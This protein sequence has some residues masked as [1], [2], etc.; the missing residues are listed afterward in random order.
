MK[1]EDLK[2]KIA[3]K[4][5]NEFSNP[6]NQIKAEAN[7]LLEKERREV[8]NMIEKITNDIALMVADRNKGASDMVKYLTYQEEQSNKNTDR[9]S[10]ISLDISQGIQRLIGVEENKTDLSKNEIAKI[11]KNSLV[12][13]K[14]LF[15]DSQIPSSGRLDM[16]GNNRVRTVE[17]RFDGYSL[18]TTF[19]WK[20][21]GSFTWDVER[22]N[23]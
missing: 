18:I 17:E 16:D 14:N 3:K 4:Q 5:N 19:D 21:D 1:I 11:I 8:L 12:E 15:V 7:K 13:V 9:V 22:I 23:D 2:N 10:E 6:A 20:Q